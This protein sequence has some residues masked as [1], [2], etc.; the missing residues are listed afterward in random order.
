[1]TD[2]HAETGKRI[3]TWTGDIHHGDARGRLAEMPA[4]AVHMVMTSPPYYGLRDYGEDVESIW[5]GDDDCDHDW[6]V[7]KMAAQGGENTADNPPDVGGNAS[8]QETRIRGGGGVESG[9]CRWCGAWEGQLGLEPSLGQF[10]RNLVEVGNAVRG[11]LRDDG[12]WWLNLGDS[13][14]SGG[15]TSYDANKKDTRDDFRQKQKMLVPHRVAIALQDAGWIVR[16]DVVWQKVNPMPESATD[17]LSTTFE[18]VFHL[19]PQSDYY[20]DLDA[21]REPHAD[22][23]VERRGREDTKRYGPDDTGGAEHTG[24]A[25]NDLNRAGKNPGDIFEV[26]TRAFPDAHF[27][28]YPKELVEKPLKATCPE[29]VCA[30]C[31]TPYEREGV[32]QPTD[33]SLGD[34]NQHCD[35]DTA[36]TKPGIAL[37][38]FAGAG[39]TCKVAKDYGRRFIGVE[40]NREYVALAQKHVGI[41]VDNPGLLTDE[42]TATLSQ[43][44]GTNTDTGGGV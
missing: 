23:S 37:D 11:V 42:A 29:K 31:G 40:L 6:V 38:P 17:R 3:E 7:E 43:F 39:T 33:V 36:D 21:I 26:A 30:D 32:T 4:S 1:M 19:T 8:T 34:W 5:G 14:S 2:K 41:D 44:H 13:Y 35:C 24:F 15:R 18:Y 20:Y 10:V 28:V 9:R 12:S 25:G 22:A 27:A 16:N